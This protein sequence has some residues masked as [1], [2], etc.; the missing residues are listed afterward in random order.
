MRQF[1]SE[2]GYLHLF[3]VPGDLQDIATQQCTLSCKSV[4]TH[5][6]RQIS[7]GVH[8]KCTHCVAAKHGEMYS[9]VPSGGKHLFRYPVLMLWSR[10]AQRYN[11]QLSYKKLT[12]RVQSA[13]YTNGCIALIS[14]MPWRCFFFSDHATTNLWSF[15]EMDVCLPLCQQPKAIWSLYRLTWSSTEI[16]LLL[17][18]KRTS[19]LNLLI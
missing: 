16:S 13:E 9:S 15:D 3:P 19:S 6:C 7:S 8:V 18:L 11:T 1:W 4:D 2:A 5:W 17:N 12:G 10:L 14:I